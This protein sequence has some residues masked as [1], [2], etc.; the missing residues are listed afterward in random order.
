MLSAMS[1]SL[2]GRGD[3]GQTFGG[4]EESR[5]AAEQQQ[6]T[7]A[8]NVEMNIYK[9][10][11]EQV[12]AGNKEAAATHNAITKVVGDDPMLY[13][14]VLSELERDPESVTSRNVDSKV[15]KILAERGVVPT[16]T[17]KERLALKKAEAD[18]RKTEADILKTEAD[19]AA[20]PKA[21]T[22]YRFTRAGDLEPIPGGPAAAKQEKIEEA[23]KA[24]AQQAEVKADIV[25]NKV[26]EALNFLTDKE[27]ED[28]LVPTGFVGGVTSAIPGTDAF[29][30][31]KMLETVQANLGFDTLQQ[32]RDASP[33][34]GA[35]G[36]V[37]E[38]ELSLL[39]SALTNLNIGQNTEILKKNLE[40]VKRHYNNWLRTVKKAG[41][42]K[43][44]KPLEDPLGIR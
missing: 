21:P 14:Q 12:A 19:I 41:T 13:T 3:F 31:E 28:F 42:Q 32:M 34:G 44:D 39:T 43:Q 36:Q 40:D 27:E 1:T 8:A 15:M 16:T 11:Q 37:S 6:L 4:L 26:N 35:L 30:L 17:K 9:M 2:S 5:R 22:G 38:R 25:V 10:M 23:K 33:T 24:K 29:Q 18:V 20:P 7:Q